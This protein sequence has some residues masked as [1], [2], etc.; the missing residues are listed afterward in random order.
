M[1]CEWNPVR[2][3]SLLIATQIIRVVVHARVHSIPTILGVVSPVRLLLLLLLLRQTAIHATHRIPPAASGSGRCLDAWQ[4]RDARRP[5][6][7]LGAPSWVVLVC[8]GLA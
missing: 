8:E 7:A 3:Y 6:F 4:A 5:T 1:K 2:E